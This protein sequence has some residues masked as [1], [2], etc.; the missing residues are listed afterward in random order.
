[1]FCDIG[2]LL[3]YLSVHS[4]VTSVVSQAP[5]PPG[6][7][8]GQGRVIGGQFEDDGGKEPPILVTVFCS[9]CRFLL[10]KLIMFV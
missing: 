9:F 6:S 4:C 2:P 1:M 8:G 3:F 5:F 10:E 7:E